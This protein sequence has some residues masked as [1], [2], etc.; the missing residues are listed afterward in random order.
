MIVNTH[1]YLQ[2]KQWNCEEYEF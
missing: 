1:R 2:W